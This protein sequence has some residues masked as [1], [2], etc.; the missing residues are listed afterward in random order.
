VKVKAAAK[1]ARLHAKQA[2][3]KQKAK[4][5]HDKQK[6][7]QAKET[8]SKARAVRSEARSKQNV[9]KHIARKKARKAREM[10]TKAQRAAKDQ[11]AMEKHSASYASAAATAKSAWRS[12]HAQL[13]KSARSMARLKLKSDSYNTKARKAAKAAKRLKAITHAISKM[14][15]KQRIAAL[16]KMKPAQ[17]AGVLAGLP[18]KARLAALKGL[19]PKQRVAALAAMAPKV[20]VAALAVLGPQ[21]TASALAAMPKKRAAAVLHAMPPSKRKSAMA[22]MPASERTAVVKMLK[23]LK[24]L[25]APLGMSEVGSRKLVASAG[26]PRVQ[27]HVLHMMTS[28]AFNAAVSQMPLANRMNAFQHMKPRQ[29]ATALKHMSLSQRAETMS[30]MS[31]SDIAAVLPLRRSLTLF[32]PRKKYNRVLRLMK[33]AVRASLGSFHKTQLTAA[34]KV[35]KSLKKKSMPM[36]VAQLNK[37]AP[38]EAVNVMSFMEPTQRARAM[39]RMKDARAGKLLASMTKRVQGATLDAMPGPQRSKSLVLLPP[40]QLQAALD[41]MPRTLRTAAL[42]QMSLEQRALALAVMTPKQRMAAITAINA[43]KQ[44]AAAKVAMRKIEAKDAKAVKSAERAS[45]RDSPMPGFKHGDT[46]EHIV[47]EATEEAEKH[48]AARMHKHARTATENEVA[49]SGDVFTELQAVRSETPAERTNRALEA[50]LADIATEAVAGARGHSVDDDDADEDEASLASLAAVDMELFQVP[51]GEGAPAEGRLIQAYDEQASAV[52]T[53]KEN[54]PFAKNF[55][56]ASEQEHVK[57]VPDVATQAEF[58][59]AVQASP[60]AANAQTGQKTSSGKKDG[61]PAW[62]IWVIVLAVLLSVCLCCVCMMC[63]PS[64]GLCQQEERAY[65]P[66][67]K[68][69]YSEDYA[70]YATAPQDNTAPPP[71][72]PEGPSENQRLPPGLGRA[73]SGSLAPASAAAAAAPDPRR[74]EQVAHVQ[75]E[76]DAAKAELQDCPWH[77]KGPIQNRIAQLEKWKKQLSDVSRPVYASASDRSAPRLQN[78]RRDIA[79]ARYA[80]R[81]QPTGRSIFGGNPEMQA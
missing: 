13:G 36:Q 64:V 60:E 2:A 45:A 71:P 31:E 27:D 38:F 54:V 67:A 68:S 42:T 52:V 59:H 44:L 7:E 81:E 69:N 35:S 34:A 72:A 70:A 57:K 77:R 37:M 63:G 66:H 10:V 29:Q 56:L 26:R 33:P 78:P 25:G 32:L 8:V 58:K 39:A 24:V 12:A 30:E 62:F 53:V 20:S 9:A 74:E 28:K 49:S 15:P 40:K 21:V 14:K 80:Q 6:A 3:E 41:R 46:I 47:D 17:S 4:L 48:E 50:E 19:S 75:Q 43:Q 11:S 61:T 51:E 16:A 79:V 18:A 76:L 23:T 5:E 1:A 22:K 73:P 65:N 55:K